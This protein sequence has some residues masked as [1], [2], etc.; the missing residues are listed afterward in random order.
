MWA[1]S[2]PSREPRRLPVA[3]NTQARWLVTALSFYIPKQ[4]SLKQRQT[5]LVLVSKQKIL[6]E[7][8][9]LGFFWVTHS[10]GISHHSQE[11][12]EYE[13]LDHLPIPATRN[14]ILWW[15]FLPIMRLKWSLRSFWWVERHMLAGRQPQLYPRSPAPSPESKQKAKHSSL[16]ESFR[17]KI[18]RILSL[19]YSVDQD[20]SWSLSCYLTD[21]DKEPVLRTTSQEEKVQ[22]LERIRC[23]T[24]HMLTM[25]YLTGF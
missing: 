21:P 12:K 22:N 14:T 6:V 7:Q 23:W 17:I 5:A 20:L 3:S 1:P 24:R 4:L 16:G 19:F 10:F 13:W 18:F 8:V 2:W 25:Q 11:D 15:L 9:W